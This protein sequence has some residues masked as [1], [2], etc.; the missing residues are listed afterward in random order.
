MRSR[1]ATA[2][3]SGA[4]KAVTLSGEIGQRPPVSI[5]NDHNDQAVRSRYCQANIDAAV[6]DN[7]LLVLIQGRIE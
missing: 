6:L 2:L 3:L 1:L 4:G 7:A 5:V